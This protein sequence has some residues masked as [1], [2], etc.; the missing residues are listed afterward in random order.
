[1]CLL[2]IVILLR[3]WNE[4]IQ[5]LR[6]ELQFFSLPR[7]SLCWSRALESSM[8]ASFST[9]LSFLFFHSN[10]CCR[11]CSQKDVFA[12]L[13]GR[14]P[15]LG[16]SLISIRKY[17]KFNN[18]LSSIIQ[19]KYRLVWHENILNK[20]KMKLK[21]NVCLINLEVSARFY[22]T[23]N[24]RQKQGRREASLSLFNKTVVFCIVVVVWF[25]SISHGNQGRDGW[26]WEV[27]I[28]SIPLNDEWREHIYMKQHS[29]MR[30]IGCEANEAE[31]HERWDESLWEFLRNKNKSANLLLSF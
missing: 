29:V 13:N 18:I 30:D 28:T 14:G 7:S 15:L 6:V 5:P 1:M 3:D 24:K 11:W 17:Y 2:P 9:N 21:R 31:S 23:K 20:K 12:L 8:K 19:I 27:N 10:E 4:P 26:H 22:N 25:S 16:L